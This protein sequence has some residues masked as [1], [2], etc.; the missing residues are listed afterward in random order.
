MKNIL[1]KSARTVTRELEITHLTVDVRDEP[2]ITAYG[3]VNV[4]DDSTGE[5]LAQRDLQ[6]PLPSETVKQLGGWSVFAGTLKVALVQA[7]SQLN[8]TVQ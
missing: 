6:I 5:V 7:Q 4:I 8:N 1:E 2:Q 3:R